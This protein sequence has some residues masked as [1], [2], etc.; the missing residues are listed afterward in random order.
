MVNIVI[1][2]LGWCKKSDWS[3]RMRNVRYGY[4]LECHR[5]GKGMECLNVDYV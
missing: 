1:M 2:I 4:Q 5:V 3:V